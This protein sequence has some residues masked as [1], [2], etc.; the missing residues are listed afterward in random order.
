MPKP[1]RQR[2]PD[3]CRDGLINRHSGTQT[4]NAVNALPRR[5]GGTLRRLGWLSAAAMLAVSALTPASVAADSGPGSPD[6]VPNSGDTSSS[7][8]ILE[9]G[10]AATML[11]D[12][13]NSVGS[14]S[15][16]FT[17]TGTGHV[18]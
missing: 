1:R 3:L 4:M 16:T 8:L 5:R 7:G 17:F 9:M 12:A 13:N 15:G 18:V 6:F 2:L 10:T 14:I 11:C